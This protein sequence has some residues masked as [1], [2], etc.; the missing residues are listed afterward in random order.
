MGTFGLGI[1]E[2]EGSSRRREVGVQPQ[3]SLRQESV[4]PQLPR[5]GR[6]LSKHAAEEPAWG[7]VGLQTSG[8][9]RR[10]GRSLRSLPEGRRPL[11]IPKPG[12]RPLGWPPL[13]SAASQASAEANAA[14]AEVTPLLLQSP[15]APTRTPAAPHTCAGDSRRPGSRC[16]RQGPVKL[17][18]FEGGP[19][20]D[21]WR[22]PRSVFGPPGFRAEL[23]KPP[24][25]PPASRV[26]TGAVASAPAWAGGFPRPGDLEGQRSTPQARSFR[27]R[28]ASPS[29]PPLR[30]R[31]PSLVARSRPAPDP[32]RGRGG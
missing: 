28:A 14:A 12:P 17:C 19:R 29:S 2:G 9:K 7:A 13:S 26:P 31:P 24:P 15:Q 21:P 22:P 10:W 32:G 4:Y 20:W 1:R 11:L 18:P 30:P 6:G 16:A 25:L 8:R 3:R 23:R 5:R 27:S